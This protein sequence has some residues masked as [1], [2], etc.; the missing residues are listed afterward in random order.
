MEAAPEKQWWNNV[1]Y[2]RSTDRGGTA[3][4]LQELVLFVSGTAQ[5]EPRRGGKGRW[6]HVWKSAAAYG[7]D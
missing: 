5:E 7:N 3:A 4:A 2:E 1:L 6:D